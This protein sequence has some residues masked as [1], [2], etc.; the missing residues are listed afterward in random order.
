MS[1][2][3]LLPLQ[4]LCNDQVLVTLKDGIFIIEV[5]NKIQS[6]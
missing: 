5:I 1:S 4:T 3:P 2:F 6:H